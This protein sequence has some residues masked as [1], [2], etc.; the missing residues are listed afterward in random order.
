MLRRIEPV[1]CGRGIASL[2]PWEA[3]PLEARGPQWAKPPPRGTGRG[4]R[5]RWQ[6][7]VGGRKG[8]GGRAVPPHQPYPAVVPGPL[9]RVPRLRPINLEGMQ[10][11]L[12]TNQFLMQEKYQLMHLRSDSVGSTESGDGSDCEMDPLDMD[13]YLYVLENAHGA[14]LDEESPPQPGKRR[15]RGEEVPPSPHRTTDQQIDL[16]IGSFLVPELL[17]QEDSSMQYFPSED[18]VL[19]S[20]QFMERDFQEFCSKISFVQ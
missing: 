14:L 4:F 6:R 17:L 8:G 3:A 11:P 2:C 12:N 7:R 18:D 20:E 13:Q 10:A 15:R 16:F 19:Q 9:R 1:M 5:P